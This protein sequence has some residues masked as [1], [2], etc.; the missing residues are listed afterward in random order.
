MKTHII[1]VLGTATCL[2]LL[3]LGL[4]ALSCLDAGGSP[5]GA[6]G[7]GLDLHLDGFPFA[8]E[9]D[10]GNGDTDTEEI[11]G[12]PETNYQDCLLSFQECLQ[13][14][15]DG[16]DCTSEMCNCLTTYGCDLPYGC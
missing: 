10:G 4:S 7:L 14:D 5:S 6:A 15:F 2:S 13:S 1:R 12:C 9:I 16:G 8:V 11:H 3:M